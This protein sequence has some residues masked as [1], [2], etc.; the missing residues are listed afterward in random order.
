MLPDEK[1]L[2]RVLAVETAGKAGSVA[3]ER[4]RQGKRLSD[5]A[6]RMFDRVRLGRLSRAKLVARRQR[7][8]DDA[9]FVA[10]LTRRL[11]PDVIHQPIG[12]LPGKGHM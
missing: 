4:Q 10:P 12:A 11:A 6:G 8:P 5:R 2:R 7:R 3:A 9:P 1:R